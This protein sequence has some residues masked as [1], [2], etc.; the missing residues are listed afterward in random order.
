MPILI[1]I[2]DESSTTMVTYWAESEG[3]STLELE[4]NVA[5]STI[6]VLAL[7]KGY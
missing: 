4:A 7:N 5:K 1:L 6:V 2:V 3:N